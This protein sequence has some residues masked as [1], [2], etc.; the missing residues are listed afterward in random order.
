MLRCQDTR[1]KRTMTFNSKLVKMLARNLYK[2]NPDYLWNP[3]LS[4]CIS[5]VCSTVLVYLHHQTSVC[6]NSNDICHS[7]LRYILHTF[8]TSCVFSQ[9]VEDT[10][11]YFPHLL[12]TKSNSNT[13]DDS[14]LRRQC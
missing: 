3:V 2:Y 10:P 12:A 9:F 8:H 13:Q 5:F 6:Q 14:I 1:R 11:G 4:S 7:L